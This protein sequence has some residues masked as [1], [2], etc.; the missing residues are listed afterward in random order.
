[1]NISRL[2]FL[3]SSIGI[4]STALIPVSIT[5]KN[6]TSSKS[7]S[8]LVPGKR[9][10]TIPTIDISN[11]T[12]RHTIIAQGT[13]DIRQG[14]PTTLLMP[15]GKTIY[16]TWNLGHGG[17]IGQLKKSVD[18]GRTWGDLLK[19]P[20]NWSQYENCPPLYLLTDPDGKERLFIFANRKILEDGEKTYQM[21]QSF[22]EDG[23]K[24]WNDMY[25]TPLVGSDGVLSEN[26]M[27]PTVMPFTA[28]E[29]VENGKALIGVSNLRRVGE[30]G[31]SN[32]LSQSRSEDG[33]LSWSHWRVI[34]DLGPEFYPC[35]PELIRSPDGN[36][37]LMIIREN[38]RAYNSWI[39]VSN[40]EGKTWSEPYQATASVTMDR[41][42]AAY[43]PD[44]RLVIVGRDV[45]EQSPSR[46]HFAGW[47]GRYE[48]LLEGREGLFRVKLLHTH[49][50]TEYPGLEILADET[51]VATNSVAYREGEN[52]SVVCTRFQLEELDRLLR[53]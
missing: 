22:S 26:S 14:H 44:G 24:N 18:G 46:G 25:A 49:Q 4:A 42:Q 34:L 17:P 6:R 8:D 28:I 45:A 41:H 1:M 32:V 47:V 13:N 51:F 2:N 21:Y 15:D 48:D 40:K 38:N 12:D 19:V 27:P 33:G 37:L 52:Y 50:T 36:Q 23:G 7:N 11:E 53:G 43:T 16:V 39:M 9:D 5:K 29:P 30:Y 35:E 20:D 3:K 31:R 10:I